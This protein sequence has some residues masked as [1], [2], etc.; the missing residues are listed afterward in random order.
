METIQ[1]W[2][3]K[4]VSPM[5]WPHVVTASILLVF[6]LYAVV[7]TTSLQRQVTDAAERAQQLARSDRN[8]RDDEYEMTMRRIFEIE[9]RQTSLREDVCGISK[10]LVA[11]QTNLSDVQKTTA[12]FTSHKNSAEQPVRLKDLEASTA[13]I[14]N[15]AAKPLVLKEQ[16]EDRPKSDPPRQRRWY[17]L[18][19]W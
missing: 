6:G 1:E 16:S 5:V 18:Y 7:M 8:V 11:L 4:L 15:V 12:Q 9:Q 19:L 2:R 17:L 10:N 13:K 3:R 14:I